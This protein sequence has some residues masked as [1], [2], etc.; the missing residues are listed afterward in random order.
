MHNVTS[1]ELTR[2]CEA[3]QIPVG[4]T[5]TLPAG[6]S[7]DITQTLGSTYTVHA[8][9]GLFRIATKDAD[10]LGINNESATLGETVANKSAGP[11]VPVDEKQV[12]DTLKTCYDPE[13]PVNIVDLGLVYDLQ[14]EPTAEGRSK[15][16][17]KMTLTA[18]GCGM[19]ATIA[20]DAQTK[21][22][23]LDGVEEANV[24][25][26]WDPPWHQSMITAE[27]RRILGIE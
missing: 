2:D 27:G 22:L 21:L 3:V 15:V 10:A 17:V 13:I 8:Q 16:N 24:E 26:V 12:W 7:V 20:G 23:Y 9:G 18:P 4:T 25:I 6:T 5:V 14:I 11:I 1:V 19:G